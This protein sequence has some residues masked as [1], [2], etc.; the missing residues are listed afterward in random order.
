MADALR[1]VGA[2]GAGARAAAGCG[3]DRRGRLVGPEGLRVEQAAGAAVGGGG[4]CCCCGGDAGLA[5]AADAGGLL[6]VDQ[7]DAC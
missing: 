3:G 6:L 7:S 4:A 2:E 1:V 5:G